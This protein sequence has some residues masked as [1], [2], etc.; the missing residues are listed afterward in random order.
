MLG[1]GWHVPQIRRIHTGGLDIISLFVVRCLTMHRTSTALAVGMLSAFFAPEGPKVPKAAPP[2]E[3]RGRAAFAAHGKCV[4]FL[5]CACPLAASYCG[6][7]TPVK[8][9][10][11]SLFA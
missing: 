1:P 6:V 8:S 9:Y 2:K 3:A 7:V 4:S 11:F 5:L 10:F